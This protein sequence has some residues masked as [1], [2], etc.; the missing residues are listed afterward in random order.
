MNDINFMYGFVKR[1]E[2]LYGL[3]QDD[4][5]REIFWARLRYDI[6]PT[7]TNV[8]R[9][10]GLMP[11][12]GDGDISQEEL[13]RQRKWK[14]TLQSLA[15]NSRKLLLYGAST[16]AQEIAQLLCRDKAEFYGFCDRNA[17]AFPDGI[18]GKPVVPPEYIF[19]HADDCYVIITTERYRDEI[20]AI[21]QE[22]NFPP[23]HILSLLCGMNLLKGNILICFSHL[24]AELSWTEAATTG[25]ILSRL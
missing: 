14:E 20:L 6:D 15:E 9:L 10:A 21:L 18:L 8:M 2:N 22:H 4:L 3:L 17:C 19:E 11:S 23:D 13:K 5:S 25:Q 16:M 24:T 12:L 1:A 7:M